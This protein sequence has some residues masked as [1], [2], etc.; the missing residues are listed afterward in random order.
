MIEH[1]KPLNG[2]GVRTLPRPVYCQIQWILKDY[3]RLK[4]LSQQASAADKA[5]DAVV[6]YAGDCMGL[7]PQSVIDEA[8]A[9][10]E[11]ID[12][13]LLIVPE[14]YR[15]GIFENLAHKR[16]LPDEASDNTWKKWKKLFVETLARE[17]K[18]Y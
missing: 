9:K 16:I 3:D 6:F 14:E 1:C 13:A 7:T 5:G 2:K 4:A 12:R 17:L 10:L 8:N 11:A 18:L 15:N